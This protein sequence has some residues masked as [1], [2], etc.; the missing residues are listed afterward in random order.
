LAP[1]LIRLYRYQV[2]LLTGS[3]QYKYPLRKVITFSTSQGTSSCSARWTCWTRRV[4]RS[5]PTHC[6]IAPTQPWQPGWHCHW[7]LT[8]PHTATQATRV[9]LGSRQPTLPTA[10]GH[11]HIDTLAPRAWPGSCFEPAVH[12]TEMTTTAATACRYAT[13]MNRLRRRLATDGATSDEFEHHRRATTLRL[14]RKGKISYG[15]RRLHGAMPLQPSR[16]PPCTAGPRGQ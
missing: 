2:I 10:A 11:L 5:R 4:A 9:W 6:A 8:Q 15:M 14:T 13:R 1:L 12:L 3:V 7:S 16:C